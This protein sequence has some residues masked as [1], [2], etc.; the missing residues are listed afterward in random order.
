MSSPS[1]VLPPPPGRTLVG[2]SYARQL[3]RC[4]PFPDF[5]KACLEGE[6]EGVCFGMAKCRPRR[7]RKAKKILYFAI[8]PVSRLL[9]SSTCTSRACRRDVELFDYAQRDMPG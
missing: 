9:F 7:F 3:A 6:G 2:R 4:A 8:E 1:L 5:R